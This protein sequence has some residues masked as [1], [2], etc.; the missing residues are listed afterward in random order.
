MLQYIQDNHGIDTESSYPYDAKDETCHFK[1]SNIGATDA[2]FVDI[3]TAD[4]YPDNDLLEKA[5]AAHGPISVAIDARHLSFFHYS[6]GIYDEPLCDPDVC[7][8]SYVEM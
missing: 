3:K 6:H 2:G 8:H 5:I 7:V 4:G 1:K